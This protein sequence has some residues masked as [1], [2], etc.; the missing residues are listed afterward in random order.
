MVRRLRTDGIASRTFF[1]HILPMKLH[2]INI[3]ASVS[4]QRERQLRTIQQPCC[5]GSHHM[6][7]RKHLHCDV[8]IGTSMAKRVVFVQGQVSMFTEIN[9]H[10]NK[11]KYDEKHVS[12]KRRGQ[13][14]QVGELLLSRCPMPS[15]YLYI[16]PPPPPPQYT[17]LHFYYISLQ[18]SSYKR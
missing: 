7:G 4:K 5:H 6:I 18:L 17:N 15:L 9:L 14:F 3:I 12:I 2:G 13:R 16:P 1:L 8:S 11:W 10:H